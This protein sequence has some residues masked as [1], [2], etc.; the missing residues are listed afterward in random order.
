METSPVRG[1]GTGAAPATS[2]NHGNHPLA[3]FAAAGTLNSKFIR[4]L[5]SVLNCQFFN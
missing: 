4:F 5:F 2:P 3:P 1:G